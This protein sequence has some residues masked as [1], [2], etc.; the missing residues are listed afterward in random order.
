MIKINKKLSNS[1]KGNF[2]KSNL[3]A[4]MAR[5]NLNAY[6]L[7]AIIGIPNPTLHKLLTED[8]DPRW[9]T[10]KQIANYFNC[11]KYLC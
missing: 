11:S 2:L 10:L 1:N 7:S 5:E 8:I 9:S 6:K 4:F 3:I